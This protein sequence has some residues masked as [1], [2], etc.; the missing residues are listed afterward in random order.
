MKGHAGH[1]IREDKRV[2]PH[3]RGMKQEGHT[4]LELLLVFAVIGLLTVMAV[5]NLRAV[6]SRIQLKSVTE[7]IAAELR[8]AR[9][10]ART[11]RDRVIVN[12]DKGRE[13]FETRRDNGATPHHL[14]RYA[15]KGVVVD[16]PSAGPEILF[17]P[18]GRSATATTIRLHHKDGQVQVMTI[19]ITGRVTIQ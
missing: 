15:G 9:Q 11:Q 14:Y 4:L 12:F 3:T 17:H 8:L 1:E 5:P 16:E 13:A 2:S 7:E 19:G 18:S 6:H 10:M